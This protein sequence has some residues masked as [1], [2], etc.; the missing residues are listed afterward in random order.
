[1]SA[2]AIAALIGAAAVIISV[3]LSAI[4]TAVIIGSKWGGIKNDVEDMK[5]DIGEIRGMFV[6]TLKKE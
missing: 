2:E 5:K 1:M 4:T 6:L 3:F